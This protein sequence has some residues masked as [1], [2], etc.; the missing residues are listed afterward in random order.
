MTEAAQST[1]PA[2]SHALYNQADKVTW[3]E[4]D[5]IELYQRPQIQAV[6]KGLANFGP[7]GLGEWN[8]VK[9]GWQK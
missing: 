8:F 4:G 1:G 6:R 9:M 7:P 2:T 3:A 5:S